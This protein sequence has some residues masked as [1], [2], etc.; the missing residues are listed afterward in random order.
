MEKQRRDFA[1]LNMNRG[2]GRHLLPAR[3]E[4]Q[5]AASAALQERGTQSV[6][7]TDKDTYYCGL[8]H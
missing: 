6:S 8:T 2:L 4:L 7:V 5:D 3:S 1:M